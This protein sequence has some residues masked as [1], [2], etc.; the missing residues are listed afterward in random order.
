MEKKKNILNQLLIICSFAVFSILMIYPF[1]RLHQIAVFSDWAFHASRAEQ[2]YEN[3]KAGN[4]LTYIATSTFGDVGTGSFLFYP[5]VFLYP[6][7]FFRFFSSPIT[8]YMLFL[9]LF[10]WLTLI[11]S[12]FSM[13]NYCGKKLRS[14]IF[15]LIYTIAPYHLYLGITNNVLGEFIAYTF[16]PMIFLAFYEILYRNKNEWVV[17]AMGMTFVMYSHLVSVVIVCEFLLLF[18][19]LYFIYYRRFTKQHIV[20]VLKAV[21]MTIILTAFI[22]MPFLTDYVGKQIVAPVSGVIILFDAGEVFTQSLSNQATNMGGFGIILLMTLLFGWAWTRS[23]RNERYIYYSGIFAGVIITSLVPWHFFAHTP[24]SVIQFPYRYFPYAILLLS[25]TCSYGLEQWSNKLSVKISN[26]DVLVVSKIAVFMLAALM[27]YVGSVSSD[28]SRN[29]KNSTDVYLTKLKGGELKTSYTPTQTT[30]LTNKNWKQQFKYMVLYG[31]TDYYTQDA[32]QNANEILQHK[33]YINN[34]TQVVS[35][36]SKPNRLI[37]VIKSARGASVDLPVVAYTHTITF[38]DGHKVNH[39]IS[40]RGTVI[41]D[42]K[43][44]GKHKITVGYQPS[45]FFIISMFV[46]LIGWALLIIGK[47]RKKIIQR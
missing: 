28:I 40:E 2:I 7:V 47:I 24:L 32:I 19:I 35:P 13:L 42:V 30:T 20:N 15:A 44:S 4:A 45:K 9:M 39:T 26:D 14:V 3:L 33:A 34:K 10:F 11:I 29:S 5:S 17:L 23:N 1:F 38:I 43:K 31:E 27:I 36:Q 25:I 37:Y 16:L 8:S 18:T 41:V 21:A 46:A 12:Y 22:W 6:W